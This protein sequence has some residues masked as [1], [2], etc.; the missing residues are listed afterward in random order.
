MHITAEATLAIVPVDCE[1]YNLF[2]DLL[3][4]A[5]EEEGGEL[6]WA[7]ARQGKV[8]DFKF[9]LNTPEGPAPHLAELKVVSA[10]KVREFPYPFRLEKEALRCHILPWRPDKPSQLCSHSPS[11]SDSSNSYNSPGSLNSLNSPNADQ[12]RTDQTEQTRPD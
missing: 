12:T 1:V 3:P 11:S 6:Q 9:L 5:L 4:A 7:R 2:G 10:G 8:P